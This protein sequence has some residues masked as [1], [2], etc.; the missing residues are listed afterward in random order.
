MSSVKALC[1][2]STCSTIHGPKQRPVFESSTRLGTLQS[3]SLEFA[4]VQNN[5]LHVSWIIPYL[6]LYIF[7]YFSVSS[8]DDGS[9]NMQGVFPP[10]N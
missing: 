3:W 6:P 4:T 7:P 2:K 5:K 1:S 8:A 10:A 9:K